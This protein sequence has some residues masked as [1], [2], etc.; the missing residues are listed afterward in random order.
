METISRSENSE[1]CLM[2]TITIDLFS[3][4]GGFALA[5]HMMGWETAIVCEINPECHVVL[6]HHFPNAY[7][8]GDI[9]TLTWKIINE[10]I[11]KR[12]GKGW[13]NSTRVV[14]CGGFPCQPYSAAGKRLGKED[15]RHLWPEMLRV[16]RECSPD[17]VVG[18]N[19][20]G[21]VSWDGGLVFEEVQT[22]LEAEGFEVQAVVVPACAVGAPHRRDRV[23]FVA[24]STGQ[25]QQRNDNRIGGGKGRENVFQENG[26]TNSIKPTT[27]GKIQPITHARLPEPQGRNEVE[28]GQQHGGW[29]IARGFLA[30]LGSAW[31]VAN[32]THDDDRRNLG[33]EEGRQESKLGGGVESPFIANADKL[34]GD[35][36]GL[37]PSQIPQLETS[38]IRKSI[39]DTPKPGRKERIKDGRRENEK[40]GGGRIFPESE[41]PCSESV[42]TYAKGCGIQRNGAKGK[43]VERPQSESGLFGR[44][45][46]GGVRNHWSNFPTEW[47]L[48]V[49]DDGLSARLGRI[50]LPGS[51]K[52]ITESG[53]NKITLKMAGNAVVPQ[54]VFEIFKALEKTW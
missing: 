12:Y 31:D 16:I 19:V 49:G 44:S 51:G 41:R 50:R 29:R 4:M 46:R 13:R 40:E 10:E 30:S 28:E 23:W 42:A 54:V 7:L 33:K 6:N 2:R 47:P 17:A 52:R 21:I 53:L 22:D 34:N 18:E 35:G 8:H 15:A 26:E 27:V 25:L 39:A 37:H 1:F 45:D 36:T 24:N 48:R 32:T 43:Q 14:L 3:G 11:E 9:H 38:G 5:A 20:S